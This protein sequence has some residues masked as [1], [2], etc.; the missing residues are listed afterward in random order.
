M[1]ADDGSIALV[2]RP[3][4]PL[5]GFFAIFAVLIV[6]VASLFGLLPLGSEDTSF[7]LGVALVLVAGA[8]LAFWRHRHRP[9][10]VFD[11]HRRLV[12]RRVGLRHQT[13]S[14]DD[15]KGVYCWHNR[16][17]AAGEREETQADCFEVYYKVNDAREVIA[18]FETRSAAERLCRQLENLVAES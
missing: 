8:I 13:L 6:A 17:K 10:W 3:F 14:F 7:V 16:W 5:L 2:R 11:A 9:Q 4:R 18:W 15:L 12:I 1:E